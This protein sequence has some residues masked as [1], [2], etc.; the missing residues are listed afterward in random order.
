M[1]QDPPWTSPFS[2]PNFSGV[3]CLVQLALVIEGVVVGG[4]CDRDPAPC[5]PKVLANMHRQLMFTYD[6]HQVLDFVF[7]AIAIGARVGPAT[8]W[9]RFWQT[10]ISRLPSPN[11]SRKPEQ[12][13]YET[14]AE[15]LTMTEQV[16]VTC[17]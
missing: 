15:D 5:R 7:L 17:S 8:W 3:Y 4:G 11:L 12:L 9:C 1:H 2:H 6:W 13:R 10:N 14:T 16:G